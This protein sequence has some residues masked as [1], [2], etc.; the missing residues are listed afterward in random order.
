MGQAV[1]AIIMLMGY[2]IIAVPTGIITTEL[3]F[4]KSNS[5][6]KTLCSV[7]E[8]KDLVKGSLFCRHCGSKIEK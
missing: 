6:N 8:K 4:S 2:S 7:C 5:E 3:T 1:S